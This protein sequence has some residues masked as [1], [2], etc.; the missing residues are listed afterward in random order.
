M[1]LNK[2]WAIEGNQYVKEKLTFC[3][4][5][6]DVVIADDISQYRELKLRMLNGTHTLCCGLAFLR[7]FQFV[8]VAMNDE[9]FRQHV[10]SLMLDE[11]AAGIPLKI[12][13]EIVAGYGKAVLDRFTNPHIQHK[14]LGITVQYT[15]KMIA[16]VLPV[17]TTYLERN[18]KVPEKIAEGFAAWLCFMRPV[19]KNEGNFSG[20]WK[21][22]S[23]PLNDDYAAWF[24]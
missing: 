13:T 17:L 11:I 18:K 4:A 2:L 15:S 3:N 5:D 16:R 23:Y 22:V 19:K 20:E 7:G 1:L 9:Q 21:G 8:S 12:D 6:S 10:E 14:W 24:F